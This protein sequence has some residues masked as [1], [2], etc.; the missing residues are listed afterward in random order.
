MS[1]EVGLTIWDIACLVV[2]AATILAL[3]AFG[4]ER[5]RSGWRSP[6]EST[7]QNEEE[8]RQGGLP[9]MFGGWKSDDMPR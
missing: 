5:H 4:I 9:R 7:R 1:E 3:I 8:S 6:E 2:L